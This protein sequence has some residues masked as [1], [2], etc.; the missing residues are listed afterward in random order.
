MSQGSPTG[1]DN[2]DD[3]SLEPA[4]EVFRYDATTDHLACI[5]CNPS[6]ARPHSLRQSHEPVVTLV[7]PWSLWADQ[8]LAATL[9]EGI[10]TRIAGPSLYR[11][12]A[13]LDKGRVF[14]NAFDS[15]APADSNGQWDVYQ[16]EPIGV[17]DCS[18]SSGGAAISRSAGGCVSLISSGT[19]EEE[20]AFADASERGDDAF[21]FT[22]AQLNET[23]TDHE[24]D[25]YDARVDGIPATFPKIAEC[26]GEAC[27][28]AVQAPNDTTPASAAFRGP[29]NPKSGARKHCGKGMRVVRHKGHRRCVHK[30]RNHG[31][32]HRSRSQRRAHR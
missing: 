1:Y 11:P 8:S 3:S 5:S 29:G 22:S 32:N 9:P 19:A 10:S 7:N 26:L 13:V 15:L 4:Q 28:A 2:R 16:Y 17:G 6:G 30:R 21:F 20:A 25:V 18:V 12:R 27:Q 31:K 14:F 24:L 23:D